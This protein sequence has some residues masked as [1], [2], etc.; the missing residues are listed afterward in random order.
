MSMDD[1]TLALVRKAGNLTDWTEW[2]ATH[3]GAI[4]IANRGTVSHLLEFLR[5]D[6]DPSTRAHG[7]FSTASVK[8]L[9]SLPITAWIPNLG[10]SGAIVAWI[11]WA[12]AFA[13]VVAFR[14]LRVRGRTDRKPSIVA[15]SRSIVASPIVDSSYGIEDETKRFR[16]TATRSFRNTEVSLASPMPPQ[17]SRSRASSQCMRV[18][19]TSSL[20]PPIDSVR[21]STPIPKSH[22]SQ[23]H[24]PVRKW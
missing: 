17:S 2:P 4:T 1:M 8:L 14:A 15:D 12:S 11:L 19:N 16:L 3:G 5:I 21:S 18:Y 24:P 23:K 13:L 9:L 6:H 20:T 7:L 10:P 22:W